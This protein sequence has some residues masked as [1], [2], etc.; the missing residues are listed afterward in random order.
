MPKRKYSEQTINAAR[1]TGRTPKAQQAFA[2]Q[3]KRRAE[4]ARIDRMTTP[5]YK[6]KPAV[7]LT[8]EQI[9]SQ[10]AAARREGWTKGTAIETLEE[11]L[12]GKVKSRRKKD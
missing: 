4:R 10:G 7:P 11:A 3:R 9:R 8:P 12:R 6:R 2:D 1:L 5:G